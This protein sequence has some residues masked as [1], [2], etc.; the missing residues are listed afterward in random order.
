MGGRE[1]G[2]RA[3]ICQENFSGNA[4]GG[5]NSLKEV[6]ELAHL[7]LSTEG[8]RVHA[9]VRQGEGHTGRPL[10]GGEIGLRTLEKELQEG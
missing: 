1:T 6:R 3:P 4:V 2:L 5:L 9:I 8:P 10:Q 7:I